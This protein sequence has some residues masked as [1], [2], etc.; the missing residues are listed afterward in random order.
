[1]IQRRL[2]WRLWR[3]ASCMDLVE[4]RAADRPCVFVGLVDGREVSRNP[5]RSVTGVAVVL[6]AGRNWGNL[7]P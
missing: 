3:G 7:I 6:I 2:V 1:M 4:E 5:I